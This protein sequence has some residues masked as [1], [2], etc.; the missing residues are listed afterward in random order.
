MEAEKDRK[1]VEVK[2]VFPKRRQDIFSENSWGYKDCYYFY[3]EKDK[4]LSFRGAR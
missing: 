2:S 3:N 4:V 1:V